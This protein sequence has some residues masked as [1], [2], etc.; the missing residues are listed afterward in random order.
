MIKKTSDVAASRVGKLVLGLGLTTALFSPFI[1]AVAGG[2]ATASAAMSAIGLG[3]AIP[4]AG[5][6]IFGGFVL[7]AMAM[8]VVVVGTLVAA[9][10]TALATKGIVSLFDRK[11]PA[12]AE[13]APR[14]QLSH[15]IGGPA[16]K[17]SQ[18]GQRFAAAI[19][20]NAKRAKAPQ[21]QFKKQLHFG[22]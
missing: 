15:D 14:A 18:L 8:P 5:A 11:E 19:K 7:G 13:A 1:G 2:W 20:Q 12:G 4:L 6:G 22:M 9:G 10:V 3:G 21:P 16:F 17:A